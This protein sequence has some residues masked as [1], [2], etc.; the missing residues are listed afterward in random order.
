MTKVLVTGAAG[1]IGRTLRAGLRGRYPLLRLSD[2]AVQAP[3]GPGED[4]DGADLTDIAQVRAAVAEMDVVVHLG[5][6]PT[7]DSWDRILATNI[8][9]TYNLFEAARLEGVRR[10]VFAS[11]NH[12]T[13]YH[14]RSERVGPASPLRPDS[15]YAVSKVT[16][17]ALGRLYADKHGIEVVCLRIGSFQPRP[18]DVRMLSTWISPADMVRLAA[19][20]I[21][22]EPVHFEILYGVSANRR[23]IWDNPAA[24]RFGYRPEDDAERFA[25]ELL[26]GRGACREPEGERLFHGGSF[27]AMEFSGEPGRIA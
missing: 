25:A 6:I 16:G 3:P 24:A 17:E 8:Q 20:A 4:L 7:E 23:A 12:V 19:C 26:A 14:R 22:A 9:G 10:V 15:R 1:G 11:S 27:C 13:G 18:L 2:V 5:G 21:E